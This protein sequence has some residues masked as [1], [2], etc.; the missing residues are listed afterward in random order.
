VI[1]LFLTIVIPNRFIVEESAFAPRQQIPRSIRPP[2]GRT[3]PALIQTDPLPKLHL[4][5]TGCSQSGRFL[6]DERARND[7]K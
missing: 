2:F 6:A 1:T 7:K 3:I 5:R 4:G